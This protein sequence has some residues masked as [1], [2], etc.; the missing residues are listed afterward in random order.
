MSDT[1][2]VVGVRL[3]LTSG[4]QPGRWLTVT[5]N[6][7]VPPPEGALL[8][9]FPKGVF[10]ALIRVGGTE[11]RTPYLD[12]NSQEQL[13]GLGAA[14][15]FEIPHLVAVDRGQQALPRV[16]SKRGHH[17]PTSNTFTPPLPPPLND[18]ALVD[19]VQ[20]FWQALAGAL[21]RRWLQFLGA[22]GD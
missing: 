2:R 6:S 22:G 16:K 4:S 1:Q 11:Q 9:S 8:A 21:T 10:Y 20:W 17:A 3:M 13:L 15:V 19:Q 18:P 5:L 12:A 14:L 7:L